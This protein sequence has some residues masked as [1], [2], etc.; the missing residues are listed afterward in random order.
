MASPT[1]GFYRLPPTLWDPWL[2]LMRQSLSYWPSISQTL[3]E[4]ILPNGTFAGIVVNEQNSRD[5]QMEHAIVNDHSYGRQLG[6]LIDAV[7]A[8]IRELPEGKISEVPFRDLVGLK[9]GVDRIKHQTEEARFR[10]VLEDLRRLSDKD[11]H[12]F[13][14]RMDELMAVRTD[15]K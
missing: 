4:P 5:P 13:E 7:A 10:S 3:N 2:E 1:G 8:L 11:T 9:A 6:K 12:T 15:K 14:S